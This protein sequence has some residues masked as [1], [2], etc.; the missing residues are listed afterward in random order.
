MKVDREE[1]RQRQKERE[2]L[3]QKFV[4]KLGGADCAIGINRKTTS[5]ATP[6]EE[7]A[8]GEDEEEAPP[9]VQTKGRASGKKGGGKL[10]PM[11]KQIIE[12][13][14]NH[15]DTI[16]LV[17]VGYKFRFFGE[18]AR[19]AAKELSIVCIPGKFRFDERKFNFLASIY[20]LSRILMLRRPVR[21]SPRPVRLCEYTSSKITCSCEAS[22]FRWA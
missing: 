7:A 11:E 21:S 12:I 8:E 13:K 22:R 5:E 20:G 6:T 2:K 10:T 15:M 14:R 3:H 19:I 17:E 16:L 1:V 18:D 9:P 4:R